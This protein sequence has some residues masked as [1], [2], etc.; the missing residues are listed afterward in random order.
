VHLSELLGCSTFTGDVLVVGETGVN[1]VLVVGFP[2]AADFFC[3][4]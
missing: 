2:V 3:M 1:L 4:A